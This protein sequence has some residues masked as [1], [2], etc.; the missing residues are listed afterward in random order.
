VFTD[1]VKAPKVSHYTKDNPNRLTS[2]QFIDTFTFLNPRWKPMALLMATT[3][4]RWGEASA[5]HGADI[6]LWK[7]G[8]E[9]FGEATIRHNNDKGDLVEKHSST[10]GMDRTVPLVPEVVLLLRPLLARAGKGPVFVSRH[11]KLYASSALFGRKLWEAEKAAEVPYRVKPHG[12][13]RTEAPCEQRS[14]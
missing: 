13:R 9:T 7:D 10:K 11:G 2:Q 3:G 4:L 12:L 6:K 5:L 14:A 8:E 1:R